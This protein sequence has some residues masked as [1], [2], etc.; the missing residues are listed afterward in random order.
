[1]SFCA[2]C[3]AELAEG[4]AI[5]P[6][7]GAG[8]VRQYGTQEPAVEPEVVVPQPVYQQPVY[9]EPAAQSTVEATA[10]LTGA[11]KI[12]SII[13]MVCGLVSLV[14][15]YGGFAPGIAALILSNMAFKKAPGVPNSKAKV[16]K[17][18]GI[19]GIIVSALCFVG[20]IVY[21][22]IWGITMDIGSSYYY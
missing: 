4:T 15:C 21:W 8:Q 20:Y 17:I 11:A 1:M 5:C 16:G 22:V 12:L 6:Y 2:N 10:T 19:I 3:G 13:S 14:S 9:Q 18:T 7:C